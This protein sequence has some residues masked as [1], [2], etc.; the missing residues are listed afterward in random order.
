[1]SGSDVTEKMKELLAEDEQVAA[2]R[3]FLEKRLARLR[4]I[5]QKL[6]DFQLSS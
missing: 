2:R 1:M 6:Y 3:R 4:V 5:K